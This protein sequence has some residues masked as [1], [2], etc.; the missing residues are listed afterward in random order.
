M[1]LN[2]DKCRPIPTF[3]HISALF[4]VKQTKTI[5]CFTGLLIH[6][7]AV[8]EQGVVGVG[9]PSQERLHIHTQSASP[10]GCRNIK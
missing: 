3:S 4:R 10:A 7:P 5:A 9:D 8:P 6:S 2:Q 1:S